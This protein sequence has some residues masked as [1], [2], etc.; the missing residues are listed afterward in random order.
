MVLTLP[1][2]GTVTEQDVRVAK[3][4]LE[5][6]RGKADAATTRVKEASDNAVT[7]EELKWR[8][9]F[10]LIRLIF[11]ITPKVYDQEEVN[12]A[13]IKAQEDYDDANTALT[14][15]NNKL[16]AA[17]V[18]QDK[19]DKE[20]HEALTGYSTVWGAWYAHSA[21]G[22]SAGVIQAHVTGQAEGIRNTVTAGTEDVKNSVAAGTDAVT[23][24][25]IA[26]TEGVKKSVIAG[27]EGVKTHLGQ[28]V[29]D[30][31]GNAKDDINVKIKN[32]TDTVTRVNGVGVVPLFPPSM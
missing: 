14:S 7:A 2:K 28:H 27:N 18:D 13:V 11:F 9:Q 1:Q 6:A 4:A 29:N 10:L 19:A 12:A 26:G 31:L 15:A 22:D 5:I 23:R 16:S 25:V 30:S 24:S 32:V 17:K 3:T 20:Y 21:I 8:V